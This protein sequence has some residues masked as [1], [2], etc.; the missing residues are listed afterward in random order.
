MLG[1]EHDGVTEGQA[2][3]GGM[4]S[5]GR[6]EQSLLFMS[7]SGFPAHNHGQECLSDKRGAERGDKLLFL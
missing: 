6:G 3:S 1:K 4:L 2:K 5:H 7:P